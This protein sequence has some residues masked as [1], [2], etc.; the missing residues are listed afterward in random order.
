MF[1]LI[2]SRPRLESPHFLNHHGTVP[3]IVEVMMPVSIALTFAFRVASWLFSSGT[4]FLVAAAVFVPTVQAQAQQT[5]S[6]PVGRVIVIGEG[7][8][9]VTPD[10]AQIGSGVTTRA[11]TVKEA[12]DAN[13]KSM[14]AITKA[15]LESGVAQRD[16][17]PRDFQSSR[18]MRRRSHARNRNLPVTACP[19]KSG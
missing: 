8:V 5:Q 11:K 9:G 7:S 3:K 18:F 14:A 6:P 1:R 2:P 16:I 17:R 4:A 13:S 12:T 10:Y 19:T 15:L